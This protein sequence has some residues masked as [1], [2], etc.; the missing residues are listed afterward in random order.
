MIREALIYLV[1]KRTFTI[2]IEKWRIFKIAFV[3]LFL[4]GIT[5]VVSIRSPY[6]S[7]TLKTLIVLLYPVCLYAVSF[8]NKEEIEKIK[9]IVNPR[10]WIIRRV[11]KRIADRLYFRER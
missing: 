6:L 11:S 2:T 9:Q 10:N 7:I 1:G 5:T 4:Y 3:A 8:F